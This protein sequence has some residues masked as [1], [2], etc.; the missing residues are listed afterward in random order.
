V[1]PDELDQALRLAT[2]LTWHA[3]TAADATLSSLAAGATRHGA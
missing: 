2:T 1:Q 3:L